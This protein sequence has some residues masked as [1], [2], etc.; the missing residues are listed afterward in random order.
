MGCLSDDLGADSDPQK[1]IN[2]VHEM[3]ELFFLLEV[4]PSL[5]RFYETRK[6]K[7]L[8]AALDK[9]T[10]YGDHFF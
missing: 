10:G 7:K 3:F 9:I 4:R 8:F 1:M 2:A 6:L 5:W